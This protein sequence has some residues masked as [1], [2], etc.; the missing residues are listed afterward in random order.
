MFDLLPGLLAAERL[1]NLRIDFV[2]GE[3][4]VAG[5]A[6]GGDDFTRCRFVAA[7]MATEAADVEIFAVSNL[8]HV[9][10]PT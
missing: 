7:V 5:V 2:F 10:C 9:S 4:D 6:V 1:E 3:D 8:I